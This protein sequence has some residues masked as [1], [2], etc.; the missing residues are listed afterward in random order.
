MDMPLYKYE[1]KKLV[2]LYLKNG[3]IVIGKSEDYTQ[4]LD[5][6]NNKA[7]LDMMIYKILVNTD[8]KRIDSYGTWFNEDEIEK[9]E[10][11]EE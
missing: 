2:K 6:P 10:I 8:P 5:N 9:I 4:A 3:T 1:R 7:S 11:L